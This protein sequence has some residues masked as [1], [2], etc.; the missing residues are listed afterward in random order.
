MSLDTKKG[1]KLIEEVPRPDTMPAGGGDAEEEEEGSDSEGSGGDVT[2]KLPLKR[3]HHGTSLTAQR[4]SCGPV[5]KA[6][7]GLY[8]ILLY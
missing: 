8:Q 4:S 1:T 7:D 2:S 6:L 3:P 5:I